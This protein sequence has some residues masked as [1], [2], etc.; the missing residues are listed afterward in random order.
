MTTFPPHNNFRRQTLLTPFQ[1]GKLLKVTELDRDRGRKVPTSSAPGLLFSSLCHTIFLEQHSLWWRCPN[2]RNAVGKEGVNQSSNGWMGE[3]SSFFLTWAFVSPSC[4]SALSYSAHCPPLR[5]SLKLI[6]MV[7]Y[8]LGITCIFIRQGSSAFGHSLIWFLM[9]TF[10]IRWIYSI[11]ST[12][13]LK[14]N[15][16]EDG[17]S[18]NMKWCL[19]LVGEVCVRTGHPSGF[20]NICQGF[21]EAITDVCSWYS[22]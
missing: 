9:L 7:S 2:A 4:N 1:M 20:K 18:I 16:W 11:F 14:V 10:E 17:L 5:P 13:P 19:S 15:G 12:K 8:P 22:C 3:M 21:S 6:V